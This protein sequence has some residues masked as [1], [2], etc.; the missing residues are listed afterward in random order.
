MRRITSVLLLSSCLAATPLVAQ[1][2]VPITFGP[3]EN[4]P[5]QMKIDPTQEL[6]DYADAWAKFNWEK[7]NKEPNEQDLEA[8]NRYDER[9]RMMKQLDY[10]K[11]VLE[12]LIMALAI[13]IGCLVL[14]MA[15]AGRKK[16]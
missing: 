10:V 3:L 4:P 9:N 8:F 6:I 5:L 7:A 2:C 11:K 15:I 13:A 1:T 12:V 16:T 14:V